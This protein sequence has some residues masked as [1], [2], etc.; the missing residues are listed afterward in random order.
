MKP[1]FNLISSQE[2]PGDAQLSR[3][4]V[5]VRQAAQIRVQR[6][7]SNLRQ[8]LSEALK[9]KHQANSKQA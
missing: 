4:M 6:V 1:E 3:V 2:D 5:Q 9:A 8:S 7:D